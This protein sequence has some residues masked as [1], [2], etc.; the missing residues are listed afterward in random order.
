MLYLNQIEVN[1]CNWIEGSHPNS[2]ANIGF[3]IGFHTIVRLRNSHCSRL[4]IIGANK[5]HTDWYQ[6]SQKSIFN[7][8]VF[9]YEN[10]RFHTRFL[11]VWNHLSENILSCHLGLIRENSFNLKTFSK[12]D[13]TRLLQNDLFEWNATIDVIHVP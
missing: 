7:T 4:N 5:Y 12:L 13:L 6:N 10:Q 11:E 9:M 8:N 3:E 1:A 2:A